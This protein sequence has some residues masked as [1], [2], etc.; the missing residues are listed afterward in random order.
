MSI[1]IG[2]MIYTMPPS[3]YTVDGFD[4]NSDGCSLLI[5]S[6][7][8][9]QITAYLDYTIVLGLAFLKQFTATFDIHYG[10][11]ALAP[12]MYAA[13]GITVTE[14]SELEGPP[15]YVVFLIGVGILLIIMVIF[16][17]WYF[18]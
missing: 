4:G 3:S 18:K 17:I 8:E 9:D 6:I 12:S 5:A 14:S 2:E 10:K 13:S 1:H 11:I 16:C 15:L 7:P